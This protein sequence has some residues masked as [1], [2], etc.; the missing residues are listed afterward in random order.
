MTDF[1]KELREK[2][3]ARQDIWPADFP[4][5][6][7]YKSNELAGEV[8]EVCGAV[9]KCFRA[10]H[11]IAGNNRKYEDYL[12]NLKEEIGDVLICLDLLARF[13]NI[14]IEEVTRDKFNKTSKKVKLDVYL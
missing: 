3:S 4:V 5:D 12:T 6:E 8:G 14:D 9:K 10:K 11:S 13:Y 2:N 7:I 1:L